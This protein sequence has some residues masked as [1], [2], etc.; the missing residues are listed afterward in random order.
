MDHKANIS[1]GSG[2]ARIEVVRRE[3][4]PVHLDGTS[5]RNAA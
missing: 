1:W 3:D 5:E 4:T 2:S